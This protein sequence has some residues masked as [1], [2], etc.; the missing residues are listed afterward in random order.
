ML[1][2]AHK[3][4]EPANFGAM[5]AQE[6]VVIGAARCTNPQANL[7]HHHEHI[8]AANA[9]T[10]FQALCRILFSVP[11]VADLV[12]Q[13]CD[14][15][16]ELHPTWTCM[17]GTSKW[18]ILPAAWG[19]LV[20]TADTASNACILCS[21]QTSVINYCAGADPVSHVAFSVCSSGARTNLSRGASRH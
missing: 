9:S 7:T 13:L 20:P 18:R 2:N 16:Q 12:A 19:C 21:F 15:P 10:S 5:A 1:Y 4:S 11:G 14:V 17:L 8:R 3:L 6:Q